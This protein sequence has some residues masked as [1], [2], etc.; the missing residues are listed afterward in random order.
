MG[1]VTLLG[2][3]AG[4]FTTIAFLPQLIKAWTTKSTKDVSLKTFLLFCVGITLWLI[5]G[6]LINDLP[7]IAANIVSLILSL[8]ILYCKFK[9]G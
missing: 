7:I 8:G 9:Y 6:I 1:Y 5:Y 4:T 2:L 3:V